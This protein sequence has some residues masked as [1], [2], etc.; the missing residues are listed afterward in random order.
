MPKLL[1]PEDDFQIRLVGIL[2]RSR[3][4]FWHTPNESDV[5]VQRRTHLKAMGL[6][7]GIP[8]IVVITPPPIGGYVGAV[9]ELKAGKNKP[10]KKQQEWLERF[11]SCGWAVGWT[12]SM[13]TALAWFR[14]L[15]YPIQSSTITSPPVN[16]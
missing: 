6:E 3:L 13:P 11:A 12:A 1:K 2:R 14:N 9:L 15:G 8:D 7:A 4:S 5:P 16:F 10:S